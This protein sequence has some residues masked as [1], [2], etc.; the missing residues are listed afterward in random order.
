[1]I[2]QTTTRASDKWAKVHCY[3]YV[4]VFLESFSTRG[5]KCSNIEIINISMYQQY[6]KY[7]AP[8]WNVVLTFPIELNQI[9]LE[10]FSFETSKM[11]SWKISK[12][13]REKYFRVRRFEGRTW[14]FHRYLNDTRSTAVFAYLSAAI[15]NISTTFDQNTGG[16]CTSVWPIVPG[17]ILPGQITNTSC[18]RCN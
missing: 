10:K 1:M 18:Q 8:V 5:R 9:W 2:R 4:Y 16:F 6:L 3:V 15:D 7:S 17:I 14:K 12:V 13:I 11:R